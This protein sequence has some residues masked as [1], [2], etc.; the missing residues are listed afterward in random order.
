MIAAGAWLGVL[1]GGQLARMFAAAAHRLG[2][3]V[4]AVDPDPGCP[5]AGVVDR[6]ICEALD[7]P[8]AWRELARNCAAVTIETENVPVHA[9]RYLARHVTVVPGARPLA[10]TQD[11]AAE[12]QF[13]APQFSDLAVA[14]ARSR[15]SRATGFCL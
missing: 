13:L 8:A 11:R 6:L 1:G 12:K 9:L 2:F 5:A 15:R 4:A 7:N 10:I 14:L 3:R